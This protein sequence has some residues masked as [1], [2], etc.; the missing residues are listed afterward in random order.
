VTSHLITFAELADLL[1]VPL[2]QVHE[3]RRGDR[4]PFSVT[5]SRG[6][7]VTRYDLPIWRHAL[8]DRA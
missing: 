1:G 2:E 3:M 4:L 5:Q 8:G 6:F 7:V